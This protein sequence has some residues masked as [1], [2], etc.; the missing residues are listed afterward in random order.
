MIV[1]N[2]EIHS[3]T[4]R[5]AQ[6]HKVISLVA[7]MLCLHRSHSRLFWPYANVIKIDSMPPKC[8]RC[9]FRKV[10]WIFEQ[11]DK[12][13]AEYHNLNIPELL[14]TIQRY[15]QV[16]IL[17]M[18]CLGVPLYTKH[19]FLFQKASTKIN[20]IQVRYLMSKNYFFHW[21][22]SWRNYCLNYS[23]TEKFSVR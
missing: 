19:F 23:V 11:L 5:P 21:D 2:K 16:V 6:Q 15:F 18:S 17:I 4:L 8:L 22:L 14:I 1:A 10:R 9:H 20:N 3:G 12:M 13:F 7:R